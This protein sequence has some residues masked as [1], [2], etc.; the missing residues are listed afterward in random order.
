MKKKMLV[1]I[2]NIGSFAIL[3]IPL[4]GTNGLAFPFITGKAFTFR[5]IIEILGGIWLIL[6]IVDKKYRPKFS[7][8]L[9]SI[10]LFIGIITTAD[11]FGINP[12]RSF[13]S[14]FE[15]MDGLLN[16]LH[17]VLYFLILSTTLATEKLWNYFF[18]TTIGVS[19]TLS[20]LG[21]LQLGGIMKIN[22]DAGRLDSTIG[23]AAYFGMYIILHIFLTFFML[24]RWQGKRSVRYFYGMVL[25]LHIII[26]YFTATRGSMIGLIGGM[27]ITTIL[28]ALIEKERII[29]RR[30]AIGVIFGIIIM[31]GGFV[32]VRNQPFIKQSLILNRFNVV[33][34]EGFKN[35]PR[36]HLWLIAIKGFKER[37]ILG[38][39]QENYK[40]IFFKYYHPALYNSEIISDKPHNT[41]LEWLTSGGLLGLLGYLSIYLTTL[42]YVWFSKKSNWQLTEKS[43]M[44]GLLIGYFING[45]FLFDNPASY[46]I[47]FTFLAYIY[48]QTVKNYEE[49]TQ[50]KLTKAYHE[51]QQKKINIVAIP[52]VLIVFL[53]IYFLNVKG[54][55]AAANLSPAMFLNASDPSKNLEQFKKA[56]E[57]NSFGYEK[58][59]QELAI[60]AID[61]KDSQNINTALKQNF[62][63]L[64]LSEIKKQTKEMPLDAHN[65]YLQG[66]LLYS[67]GE[68]EQALLFLEEARKLSPK[69][70]VI[71]LKIANVYIAQKNYKQ[72]Y[73]ITK[74]TYELEPKYDTA[75]IAYTKSAILFRNF[76]KASKLL[77][78]RYGTDTI[79]LSE[80]LKAYA[81]TQQYDKIITIYKKRILEVP[82]DT[83][84]RFSLSVAYLK[85]GDRQMAVKTLEDAIA[86]DPNI[87]DTAKFLIKEIQDGKT[88]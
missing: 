82:D 37:P 83:Q 35:Q 56:L 13:W 67:Y 80:I 14:D 34:L 77:I 7:W 30:I 52:V 79:F 49:E 47:F 42:Y 27:L 38:W 19:V 64:A 33:S 74:E 39:G 26:L 88:L 29:L 20:L 9:I 15:R 5:I 32:L 22:T 48:S 24:I 18:N 16:L 85:T 57:N 43:L 87:K 70:Q 78:E 86:N 17:F 2:L 10:L 75:R 31:I 59:R 68:Y 76:K 71:L 6:T 69:K 51:K 54:I 63:D 21:L 40:N 55:M 4:I 81:E 45:L 65:F 53:T 12:Y 73:D 72:A 66:S 58:I 50:P 28:I 62:F 23:N 41:V 44:T 84:T 36:Y 11:I 1:K 25:L 61:V 60:L 46:I 8:I 3:F